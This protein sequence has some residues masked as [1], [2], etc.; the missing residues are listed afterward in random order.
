MI[1]QIAVDQVDQV[2]TADGS[3]SHSPKPTGKNTRLKVFVA[4]A[5]C[6]AASFVALWPSS[7]IIHHSSFINSAI[8]SEAPQAQDDGFLAKACSLLKVP[9]LLCAPPHEGEPATA[10]A[11]FLSEPDDRCLRVVRRAESCRAE[12]NW[13]DCLAAY[14]VM[15]DEGISADIP[16]ADGVYIPLHE[17]CRR[18]MLTLPGEAVR[19]Y[20]T[21]HDVEAVKRYEQAQAAHSPM[22]LENVARQYPLSSVAIPALVEAADALLE[23]GRYGEAFR[24][25]STVLAWMRLSG[26]REDGKTGRRDE[27]RPRKTLLVKAAA[28]LMGMGKPDVAGAV[29]DFVDAQSGTN[30]GG[31]GRDSKRLAEA[32]KRVRAVGPAYAGP[33]PAADDWG[34]FGGNNA[35]SRMPEKAMLPGRLRWHEPKFDTPEKEYQSRDVGQPSQASEMICHPVV[36]DGVLYYRTE[37]SVAARDLPTGKVLWNYSVR[38]LDG[39]GNPIPRTGHYTRVKGGSLFI[40]ADKDRVYANLFYV[41]YDATARQES[42]FKLVALNTRP[43]NQP[44]IWERGGQDDR[45]EQL[46]EI[47]FTSPPIIRGGTL[48]VGAMVLHSQEMYVL[49]FEAATGKLLWKTFMCVGRARVRYDYQSGNGVGEMPAEKDGIVYFAPGFGTAAAIDAATG[50]VLWK[51]VFEQM[52]ERPDFQGMYVAYVR[53]N[54]PPVIDGDRFLILPSDSSFLYALKCST[55]E[56]EWKYNVGRDAYLLGVKGDRVIVSG[57]RVAAISMD[58]TSLLFS[59]TLTDKPV[60]RGLIAES[61]VL[62]P[63]EEGIE[64]VHLETG[65][66]VGVKRPY[67]PW[68]DWLTFQENLKSVVQSGNLLIAGGKLIIVGEKYVQVFDEWVNQ[69]EILAE[70]K[71]TPNDPVL[72]AKLAWHY[73]REGKYDEAA[74]EYETA[75]RTITEQGGNPRLAETLL[76]DLFTVYLELGDAQSAEGE[77]GKA[78]DYFRK[79]LTRAPDDDAKL[80]ASVK[81]AEALVDAKDLAGAIDA[82]QAVIADYPDRQFNIDGSLAV[83]GSIF[84]EARIAELLRQ[85][86]RQLYAAY[87]AKAK[88]IIDKSG[89]AVAAAREVLQKYPNSTYAATSLLSIAREYMKQDEHRIAGEHL[90]VLL[91]RFADAPEAADASALLDEC[92]KKRNIA[93]QAES[94]ALQSILPPLELK[95][96]VKMDAGQNFALILDAPR[97]VKGMDDLF[98]IVL[99]KN[100]FCRSARSG[101]LI[102]QNSAG[103]LGVQLPTVGMP[104]EGGG[105]EITAVLPGTPADAAGLQRGD[106]ILEFDGVKVDDTAGLIRVCGNT[107]AGSVV[108]VKVSRQNKIVSVPVTLGERPAKHDQMERGCRAFFAGMANVDARAGKAAKGMLFSRDRYIQCIDPISGKPL[109]R[110][111]VDAQRVNAFSMPEPT[112]KDGLTLLNDGKLVS[113]TPGSSEVRGM[114]IQVMPQGQVQVPQQQQVVRTP[115]QAALWDVATGNKIWKQELAHRPISDPH[116]IGNMV[117]VLEADA[118]WQV[119]VGC[120]SAETG[121][122]LKMLGPIRCPA[123][124]AL[125][126]FELAGGRVCVPIGQDIYCY[127][128]RAGELG[129]Q[130]WARHA[131]SGDITMFRII[132][133]DKP[134]GKELIMTSAS[135]LSIE[136]L[137]AETGR[138]LWSLAPRDGR[139]LLDSIVTDG[140]TIFVCSRAGHDCMLKALELETGR[141]RWEA[142]FKELP[143]A[144]DLIVTD[145]HVMAALN[146]LDPAKTAQCNSKVVILDKTTGKQVQEIAFKDK[147]VFS[148]K[149]VN[150]VLII[151]TQEAVMGYGARG[152][153]A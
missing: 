108:E 98:Y 50:A 63:T 28:A 16:A 75:H 26:G 82:F 104:R 46:K 59:Q 149:V 89:D 88:E 41:S 39:S 3:S 55:G 77:H 115:H 100:I 24:M 58:G 61:F 110:F 14:Q 93:G 95:W 106:V 151:V 67:A 83:Q 31:E 132:P 128:V 109:R 73:L 111:P 40:T 146:Q 8:A 130:V 65:R 72:H 18:R 101:S 9:E 97:A 34:T 33:R 80:Q 103:W 29:L 122:E 145:S 113:V 153:K 120:Y 135:G 141:Q 133:P 10:I 6:C 1:E 2:D 117:M 78:L 96:S 127:D 13:V 43:A 51:A 54:N 35:H 102:W 49:A 136:V 57:T 107:A 47:T 81:V 91:R 22:L 52:P 139:D 99:G 86:G 44:V 38:M 62:C 56:A 74:G 7:F 140:R 25:Y 144:A 150:G 37:K 94:F 76:G 12:G 121:A 45:D 42:R 134:G 4:A 23:Q 68:K 87:D 142:T 131:G 53:L 152:E 114:V 112:E 138:A 48:Y 20:R 30:G 27:A 79:A 85:H 60:G 123:R 5:L 126:I 69:D 71:K 147:A 124:A 21:L 143:F 92:L 137:D 90:S 15:I 36:I 125:G 148:L 19:V 84:A 17:Y 64:M 118:D 66:F 129:R 119:Y 116:V 105:A 32:V 11:V 70:L